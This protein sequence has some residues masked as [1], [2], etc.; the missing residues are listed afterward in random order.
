MLGTGEAGRR[1]IARVTMQRIG[2]FDSG[3]GGLTVLKALTRALP[4]A[5]FVY[6]GD[7]ARLPYGTKSANTVEHYALQAARALR[8]HNVDLIVIACNTASAVALDPLMTSLAPLPVVGVVGP[9]AEAGI[10]AT[11]N[12]HIAVIATESTVRGGAYS[13]AIHAAAPDVRVTQA[14]CPLFVALAEE[15]WT[16]GTVATAAAER[17]L[18]PIF[19]VPAHERPDT[20]VLGC[21]HFPALRDVIKGVTGDAVTIVDSAETTARRVRT[22]LPPAE[23]SSADAPQ[24]L[25]TDSPERFARVGSIFLDR[26]IAPESVELVDLS[27]GS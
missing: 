27:F 15:G 24:F 8:R 1:G 13:R 14:A 10:A 18:E 9:G 19:N 11:R 4:G 23:D 7:T 2:V 17:Y 6:L 26:T 3:M 22:L 5:S 20:L 12:R 25:V 21:T 16:T